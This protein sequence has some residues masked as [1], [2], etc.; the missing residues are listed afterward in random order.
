MS[1]A[2]VNVFLDE[3]PPLESKNFLEWWEQHW[4]PYRQKCL[5][6]ARQ[7]FIVEKSTGDATNEEELKSLMKSMA[8]EM[9]L[10]VEDFM[11][12]AWPHALKKFTKKCEAF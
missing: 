9:D 4:F 11:H 7:H 8:T 2:A 10:D 1:W 12:F 6:A 5:F 3:L